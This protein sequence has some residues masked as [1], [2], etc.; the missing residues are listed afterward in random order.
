L[1]SVTI[2][3]RALVFTLSAALVTGLLFGIVPALQVSRWDVHETLKEA[4]RGSSEGDVAR[5]SRHPGGF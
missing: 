2:D 1:Q 5:G 3:A 4:S